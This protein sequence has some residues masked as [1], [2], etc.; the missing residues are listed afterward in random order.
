MIVVDSLSVRYG[1]SEALDLVDL[2]I[3]SGSTCAIIGPTGCGKSTLL[4][5]MAGLVQPDQGQVLVNGELVRA[6]RHGT[7][8]ILQ[9]YGLFPWLTARGN[10]RMAAELS[11]TAR[12]EIS[13]R[14]SELLD[15]LGLA[16]AAEHFPSQLSGGQ[17]QRVAIAR[18]LISEPDLLLMD[19]PF[20]AL[21]ALTRESMQ[22]MI[23]DQWQQRELTTVLVTH[24]IE[25]AVYLG[26]QIVVMT[27]SPGRIRESLSNPCPKT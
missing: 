24:S 17:R 3:R 7:S 2:T 1:E 5:T 27:P 15:R 18:A 9:D 11:G 10:V 14:C 26:E 4:Y 21:D 8:L 20:S 6:P 19:E 13:E 22:A 25:E 12:H 23:R 16:G